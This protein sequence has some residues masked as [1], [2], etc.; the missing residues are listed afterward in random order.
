MRG[1]LPEIL[2]RECYA[3]RGERALINNYVACSLIL[4]CDKWGHWFLGRCTLEPTDVFHLLIVRTEM[5]LKT[6]INK[7]EPD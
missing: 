5:A 1:L 6:V 2:R 7:V 4:T 3:T